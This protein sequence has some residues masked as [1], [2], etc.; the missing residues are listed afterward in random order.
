MVGYKKSTE[1]G[2]V[3]M[4][5]KMHPYT[6]FSSNGVYSVRDASDLVYYHYHFDYVLFILPSLFSHF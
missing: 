3:V 6:I 2:M 4:I 5:D 1:V